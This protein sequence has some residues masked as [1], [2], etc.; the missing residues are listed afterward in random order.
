DCWDRSDNGKSFAAALEEKGYILARG[1][2]RDFV[3]VDQAGGEHAL[4]KRITGAT[5]AVTRERLADLAQRNL[6]SVDEAKELQADRAVNRDELQWQD[7]LAAA[8][9]KEE[10]EVKRD[11]D[12]VRDELKREAELDKAAIAKEEREKNFVGDEMDVLR[13]SEEFVKRDLAR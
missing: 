4:G 6:P 3:V 9:I 11:Q 7:Q 13:I 1:D 10:D 8:A 5:A 12:T 2:R